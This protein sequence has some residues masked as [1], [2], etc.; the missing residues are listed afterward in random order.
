VIGDI[1]PVHALILLLTMTSRSHLHD[2]FKS[3][4]TFR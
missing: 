2:S 3:L 1:F 4:E